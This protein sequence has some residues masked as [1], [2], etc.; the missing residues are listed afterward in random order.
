[1]Q[2]RRDY[3]EETMKKPKPKPEKQCE[4]CGV[5]LYCDDHIYAETKRTM[6]G[7]LDAM[8]PK[9][10]GRPMYVMVIGDNGADVVASPAFHGGSDILVDCLKELIKSLEANPWQGIKP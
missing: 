5:D 2:R 1:M 4:H 7:L 9:C 8:S 6:D 10:V 3:G